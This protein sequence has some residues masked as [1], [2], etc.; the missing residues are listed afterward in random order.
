M[1]TNIP[2]EFGA[3]SSF[4]YKSCWTFVNPCLWVTIRNGRMQ[5][6]VGSNLS[7]RGSQIFAMN[8]ANWDMHKMLVRY[9]FPPLVQ[10]SMLV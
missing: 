10:T 8:A 5:T 1:N 4:E 7:M 6:R 2:W 3:L 9:V